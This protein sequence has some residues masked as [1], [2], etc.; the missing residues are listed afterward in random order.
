MVEKFL[1][2]DPDASADEITKE[3]IEV[4][5]AE[6][7]EDLRTPGAGEFFGRITE[8]G[9][10]GDQWYIGRRH[11]ED[12][13]HEPVVVDWR[14]PIAAP[15]YRATHA[16]SF[17]LAHRRRFTLADGDLTAY[18]DEQLDDPDHDTAGSGIPDPV[19]AE[20]GAA[21]TGA[22]REIVATIQAE[23]DVVIRAPLQ[24]V[25]VVQGGP[26]TGKTAVGLHRAAFLLFEHRRRLVRD[27]VLVVGPNRVFLDYIGNVLPSLGE[28]SVQQRTAL[29]LCVP[30]V[31]ITGVDSTDERR[32]KGSEAMLAELEA[33]S[34]QHVTVPPEDLRIPL[35]ARTLVITRDEIGEWFE[36]ALHATAPVNKRRDSLKGLVQRD[37]LRRYDRDDVWEKAP[38]LRAAL[39]KAWPTAQPIKLIDSLLPGP[40]GKRRRWTL[41]DQFLVDEANSLLVGTPFT[42][43]HVVVD[44]SQDHSAVALRCIGRRS[45]GGSMTILGDLAQST[46]PAGQQDWDDVV[47]LLRAEAA[48][49]AHLTIG[50]RVP[51]PILD[52]ANRLLP[53]TGV[54]TQAS[55]SVRAEGDAPSLRLVD[56]DEL[57]AAVAAE[58]RDVRH[59][60]HNSGVVAPEA[61][62]PAIADAL[63]S[64]GLRA[65]DRVHDLGHDD[66]PVVHAE[67]VKGLE[68]DGVV[69]VNPHEIFDGTERGARLLYV[70]MTRA[71][72][73]LH[74]VASAP[75][76]RALD[77][78]A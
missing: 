29:D 4:T 17:G 55:R 36:Q 46:T 65:V 42:Y 57:A 26:G 13:R 52:V 8:E 70:A 20:I 60:H 15:F 40:S 50:Y 48:E 12:E 47:R 44:E 43:G 67:A 11:I 68:F 76:P 28:R 39:T 6:A 78:T 37:M 61:L 31:E 73:V 64:I 9:V 58:V 63:E 10:A 56:A 38:A 77:G 62:F 3:Y 14:A 18:L 74:F 19:L 16:D 71:V 75:L 32:R 66:V 54:T 45:P 41:A 69:V 21:R 33:A 35:G 59:R 22:M 23:Q 27:G 24:Q 49:V 2:L 53:F 7:L 30:K 1:A 51:A 72:Q 5:V 25:L 34:T